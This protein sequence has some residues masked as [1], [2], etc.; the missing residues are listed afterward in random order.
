MATIATVLTI[1]LLALAVACQSMPGAPASTPTPTAAMP[2]SPLPAEALPLATLRLE[3]LPTDREFRAPTNLMPAQ[4]GRLLV[5]EQDGR[6]WTL[7]PMGS[8]GYAATELLDITDRVSSRGSEEGLLGLALDPTNKARLYVYYSASSPRRSVVSRFNLVDG[9]SRADPDSELV[10]LEVEQ[11]Y[12][13]HNGGQ[14]AFGPDGYL[15]VGLG[16]GG[17]AGDPLGSGQDT[18]TLLGAIL[19]I[20]VSQSTPE[21]PYA[22][23]PD[24]PFTQGGGRGEIWAY[25]LRNPWRFSFDRETGELW[26]GDVGQNRWEEIDLIRRGGNYG[27]NVLEGNH[28]FGVRGGCD[29]GGM[30]PPV[31]EYSLDGQPCSV[32][33]GY[34]YRGS[35]I[36]WLKGIYVY[37]DFCSGEVFG[38]RYADG[39]VVEHK[40]LIDTD[41]RIMSFAEDNDGE[42][43]LLSQKSGIYRLTD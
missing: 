11:P 18:S 36:P 39:A 34:V 19:R 2:S 35:A 7:E 25:G 1:L 13:N 3:P 4:N 32:I 5:T 17:S 22:I 20:D 43:Y 40:R 37:G 31:W 12:A 8:A 14:I 10:I 6:I 33:G 9:H 15:Y 27:W 38:L 23:P 41:L 29:T 16:D 21:R 24:N 30:V 42:L 28:C 26:A